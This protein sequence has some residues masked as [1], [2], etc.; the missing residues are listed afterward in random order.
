MEDL[1]A[2]PGTAP[3][4]D[5]YFE[6]FSEDLRVNTGGISFESNIIV[7]P[8]IRCIMMDYRDVKFID[9]I[10]F[11][12]IR[13]EWFDALRALQAMRLPRNEP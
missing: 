1:A 7:P 10:A 5:N 3:M 11:L 6:F 12:C 4:A 2:H 13:A 8:K 9:K